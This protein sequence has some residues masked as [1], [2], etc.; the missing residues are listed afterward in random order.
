MIS[1]SVAQKQGVDGSKPLEAHRIN[2]LAIFVRQFRL[3]SVLAEV[4]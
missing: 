3:T 4:R 2:G 1:P